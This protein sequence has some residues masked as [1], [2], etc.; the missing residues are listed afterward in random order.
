[1]MV[2]SMVILRARITLMNISSQIV[3][4]LGSSGSDDAEG[5]EGAPRS[6]RGTAP[7]GASAP[8]TPC[9]MRACCGVHGSRLEAWPSPLAPSSCAIAKLVA[10]SA[11]HKQSRLC[12]AP[13]LM[14]LGIARAIT[15]CA[16][17]LAL[18]CLVQ[19]VL[20][21]QP[22][23]HLL[24]R[25]GPSVPGSRCD[26]SVRGFVRLP[27]PPHTFVPRV[28]VPHR[29]ATIALDWRQRNKSLSFRSRDAVSLAISHKA[30]PGYCRSRMPGGG[31]VFVPIG[32]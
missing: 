8:S 20:A 30:R 18:S 19:H 27:T 26:P 28:A 25:L 32:G 7:G 21:D 23:P 12:K 14:P 16:P 4:V 9:R 6:R 5:A 2:A 3:Q 17:V 22:M 10:S 15:P 29:A 13:A 11:Q 31:A 1:M 24:H